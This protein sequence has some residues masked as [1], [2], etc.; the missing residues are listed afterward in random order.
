MTATV[1]SIKDA[2]ARLDDLDVPVRRGDGGQYVLSCIRCRAAWSMRFAKRASDSDDAQALCS[3]C[4]AN[5]LQQILAA[6]EDVEN[7][8]DVK[9]SRIVLADRALHGVVGDYVRL[10]AP[11]TEVSVAP[12]LFAALATLGTLIGRGPT[13]RFGDADHHTRLFV[14]IVGTSGAGRKGSA[15]NL[16]A[17]SLLD[18]VDADFKQARVRSGL[19]S[20]EGLIEE[21]RDATPDREDARGRVILGDEGVRDKRLLVIE[22]E[23]GSVLEVVAREGNRLSHVIRDLWD[24]KSVRTMVKHN[25][26]TATNPHVGIIGAITPAEL[27]RRMG[28]LSIDNGLANR[29][30]PVL[31]SFA[32]ILPDDT[33]PNPETL[34]GVGRALS[35]A[36]INARRIGCVSW[37]DSAAARW[38]AEYPILRLPDT[39][40]ERMQTLLQRGA[41]MVRRVAMLYALL[42]GSGEVDVPHLEAA[43]AVWEFATATWRT[44]FSDVDHRSSLARKLSA[45]LEDAGADGLTRTEIRRAVGSNAIRKDVIDSALGELERVGSAQCVRSGTVG[46]KSERWTHARF[47]THLSTTP[48]E[49]EKRDKKDEKEDASRL[50][51]STT[52]EERAMP[53]AEAS[54]NPVT[55]VPVV[56]SLP[57][58][59]SLPSPLKWQIPAIQPLMENGAVQGAALGDVT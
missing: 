56:P 27:T 20:G 35:D 34:A 42:D 33:F 53:V 1:L 3:A 17:D 4:G 8:S 54:A 9:S 28:Q 37:T 19:S 49:R 7:V 15:I 29:F 40:D 41:P 22:S 51:A 6:L 5:D 12:I 45:A 25:P 30:L 21:L 59:L 50:V 36:V 31:S 58:I 52:S 47:A 57:S 48:A 55:Q 13:W 43:L 38:R 26:Q 11:H 14:L 46:R 18:L 23:F 24:G 44:V 2:L 16:G 10:R 32:G 39:T